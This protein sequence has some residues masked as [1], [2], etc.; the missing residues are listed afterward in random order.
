MSKKKRSYWGKTKSGIVYSATLK[1]TPD[2]DQIK[3]IQKCVEFAY[4]NCRKN[5]KPQQP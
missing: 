4:K 3:T 2:S 1:G 5:N